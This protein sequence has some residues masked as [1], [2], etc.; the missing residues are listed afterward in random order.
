[1]RVRKVVCAL[2]GILWCN[3]M[4][5]SVHAEPAEVGPDVDQAEQGAPPECGE[6]LENGRR[7]RSEGKLKAASELFSEC[8]KLACGPAVTQECTNHYTA[9]QRALPSVTLIA[10]EGERRLPEARVLDDGQLIAEK[11]DGRA[12]SVDP[13]PHVFEFQI[14]GKEPVT[15]HSYLA[16]GEKGKLVIAQFPEPQLPAVVEAQPA[17]VAS[18][19]PLTPLPPSP[20]PRRTIPVTVWIF[21]GTGVA[22]LAGGTVLRVLADREFKDLEKGCKPNCTDDETDPART[23]YILS[24]GAFGLGAAALVTASVFL[25]VRPSAD[26]S[27]TGLV[28]APTKSGMVGGWIGNF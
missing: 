5:G 6:A 13:G 22:A 21:G 10:R 14:A 25:L 1:M 27:N 17:P 16:E 12:V 28:L 9:L 7:A 15:V 11:L 2:L 19:P 20:P 23:K 26:V 4:V 8:S 24:T 3:T 18:A